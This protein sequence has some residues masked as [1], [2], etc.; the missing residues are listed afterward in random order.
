MPKQ[1]IL[2]QGS[3]PKL[4]HSDTC[5]ILAIDPDTKQL[6]MHVNP[7]ASFDT[8]YQMIFSFLPHL[9]EKSAE[10]PDHLLIDKDE[11][12]ANNLIREQRELIYD[13]VNLLAS[14]LLKNFIPDKNL[15]KDLDEEAILRLEDQILEESYASADEETKKQIKESIEKAKDSLNSKCKNTTDIVE[16]ESQVGDTSVD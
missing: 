6:Q 2:I 4:I 12:T 1:N 3:H 15:R 8:L 10:V 7:G 16:E 14:S 9:M 11:E 5:I 13:H